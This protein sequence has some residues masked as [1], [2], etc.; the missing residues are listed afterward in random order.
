MGVSGSSA[1]V[2]FMC[3]VSY[4]GFH[5]LESMGCVAVRKRLMP[6]GNWLAAWVGARLRL[7]QLMPCSHDGPRGH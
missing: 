1:F 7:W 5:E 2:A 6:P 3:Y 4:S